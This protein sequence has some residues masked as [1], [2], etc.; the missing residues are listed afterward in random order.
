[1]RQIVLDTETTGL[2]PEQ[3]HRIIEIGCVE[4][5]DRRLTGNNF[6]QYLQ[7]ERE[8]DAAAIEVHGITNEFLQDKPRFRD[9]AQ[10]FIDYVSGSELIIH[11]APFD[12]GF[13][14]HELRMMENPARVD[15]LCA[16]TDTLTMAKKMHPGQRNS[17][18][19][20]CKRYDID[21]SHREL[22]GAL[23]DAE[24]LA[25][26]YLMMTGGQASLVLDGV[27]SDA[28]GEVS[29]SGIQRLPA[30][31]PR[32][33]VVQASR[34]ELEAHELQLEAMGEACVWLKED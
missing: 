16:V 7:P 20:L 8:I 5:V 28:F 10:D 32:L 18:D 22:H 19:A 14:D 26:V 23:L 24:I 30:N 9:V 25:D 29:V 21:N 3:G 27:P 6:H 13:L 17:L 31:R 1:M 15:S 11:N 12:V 4:M 2:E 33:K 34:Q